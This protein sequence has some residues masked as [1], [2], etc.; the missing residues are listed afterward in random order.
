MALHG[1]DQSADTLS[2]LVRQGKWA[3][4]PSQVSD[5][6]LQAFAV[7]CSPGELGAHLYERY[8]GVVDRLGLYLPFVPAQRDDFWQKLVSEFHG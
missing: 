6:M 1:W 5:E 4:L 7:V 2:A 3:E 8:R